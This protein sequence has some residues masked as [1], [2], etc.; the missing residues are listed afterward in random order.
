MPGGIGWYRKHFAIPA[1]A[2]ADARFYLAFDGVYMNST[3]WVN[4]HELGTRLTATAVR[5]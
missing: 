5:I 2:A 4:G 3:V 1:E